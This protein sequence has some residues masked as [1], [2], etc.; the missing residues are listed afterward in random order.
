MEFL[1]FKCLDYILKYCI[2]L[3][4][5]GLS[6]GIVGNKKVE[7]CQVMKYELNDMV[8]YLVFRGL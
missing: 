4:C 3:W 1:L 8:C 5:I 2:Y 6:G 7:I